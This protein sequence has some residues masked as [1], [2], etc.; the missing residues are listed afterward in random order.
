VRSVIVDEAS[1]ARVIDEQLREVEP[2]RDGELLMGGSQLALGYWQDAEKTAAAFV[3]LPESDKVFYRTGD[4]GR[5]PVG[6]ARFNHL[7]RLDH[8]IK[9]M[10]HHVELREIE[11]LIRD[12][13]GGDAVVALGW[14]ISASGASAIEAFLQANEDVDVASVQQRLEARL[15]AY[16][17]RR[18]LHILSRLPLNSNAKYDRKALLNMLEENE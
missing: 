4:R 14:P 8:Q 5:R 7:G 1:Q 11:A 12:E 9:I 3:T 13:A 10:T 16:M 2:G 15:P 18:R 17:V 6:V